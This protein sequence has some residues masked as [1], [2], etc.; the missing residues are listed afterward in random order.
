MAVVGGGRGWGGG[1]FT[2]YVC[3]S[4]QYNQ[5]WTLLPLSERDEINMSGE[6]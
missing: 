1:G 5:V 3:F 6:E 4:R 2:T